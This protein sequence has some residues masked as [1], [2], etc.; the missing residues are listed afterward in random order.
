MRLRLALLIAMAGVGPALADAPKTSLRPLPRPVLEQ[1][2]LS[3]QPDGSTLAA[4]PDLPRTR[5]LRRPDPVAVAAPLERPRK[6]LLALIT[7]RA[8]PAGKP[9]AS[10]KG[11]VCGVSSIKG[12]MLAQIT[13]TIEGCGIEDPVRITSVDGVRL[14]Q[15]A[16]L[17]CTAARALDAWVQDGLQPAFARSEVVELKVA[18]HYICRTRNNV[19]GAKVSEHGSGK[20]IDIS[21][22][23]LANGKEI[24][25]Q[26]NFNG[27]MRK[28]HKAAC[29][30]FKT[31]LGPGSDGYHEDNLHYDTSSR[32]SGAYCR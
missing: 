16:T 23:V 1:P 11:S 6:G 28:A 9:K 19:S 24:A 12:E 32:N 4:T 3:A 31:T 8:K 7:P 22:F 17:D 2:P 13:S 20:A 26:G 27:A 29:G 15:P 25:V 10:A 14:S 5:P 30:F 18:A 21:G